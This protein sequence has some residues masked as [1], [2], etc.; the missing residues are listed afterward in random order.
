MKPC[1][2]PSTAPCTLFAALA[3]FVNNRARLC[4][5]AEWRLRCE[6]LLCHHCIFLSTEPI[7]NYRGNYL[8]HQLTILLIHGIVKKVSHKC[9]IKFFHFRPKQLS[10][11]MQAAGATIADIPRLIWC[12]DCSLSVDLLPLYIHYPALGVNMYV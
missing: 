4:K 9:Y 12:I 6:N 2:R 10:M 8:R 11:E 1:D 7:T 5:D 3:I